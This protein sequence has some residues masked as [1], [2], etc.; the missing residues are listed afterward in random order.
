MKALPT[1]LA[2]DHVLGIHRRIINEFGGQPGL[3][4]RGLLESAVR[5][6][7]ARFGGKFLHKGVPVM[8]AAYLFHLCSNH[9]FVDGNK[10]KALAAA[11][12]FLLLNDMELDARGEELEDLTRDVARGRIAKDKVV[13]FFKQHSKPRG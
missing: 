11:E 8:A 4:D 3:R 9:A 13:A 5:M 7:A 2:V 10:R 6:P 12:V 1:F